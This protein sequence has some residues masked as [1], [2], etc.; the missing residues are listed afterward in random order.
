MVAHA[1]TARLSVSRVVSEDDVRARFGY[2]LEMVLKER[3]LSER[4]FAARIGVDPRKVGR[5]RRGKA[6][7]DYAEAQAI[8]RELRVT[9]AIFTDPPEIPRVPAYPLRSLLVEAQRAG[10]QE[11]LRRSRD[12]RDPEP[13]ARSNALPPRETGA[14]PQRRGR[15]S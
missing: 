12:G 9:E 10:L 2:A 4:A 8:M 14:G 3:N 5:W 15:Q 13:P 1:L 7:P 11:G 6:W